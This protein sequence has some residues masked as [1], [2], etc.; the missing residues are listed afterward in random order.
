MRAVAVRGERGSRRRRAWSPGAARSRGSRGSAPRI[1]S[2]AVASTANRSPAS[3]PTSTWQPGLVEGDR[4]RARQRPARDDAR[5][6]PGRRRRA[7]EPV[8]TQ[9]RSP[10]RSPEPDGSSRRGSTAA[11]RTGTPRSLAAATSWP[12]KATIPR[13][14]RV[15][16]EVR[17]GPLVDVV[18]DAV[19]PGLEELRGGAGVV[20]LVEVHPGRV[21]EPVRAQDQRADHEHDQEPQVQPVQ[22]PSRLAG[23]ARAIGRGGSASRPIAGAQPRRSAPSPSR[24]AGRTRRARGGRGNGC[25]G[26]GWPPRPGRRPGHRHGRPRPRHPRPP[27][28]PRRHAGSVASGR[29]RLRLRP[30]T[31]PRSGRAPAGAASARRAPRAQLQDAPGERRRVEQGDHRHA[32]RRPDRA[33]DPQPVRDLGLSG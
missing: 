24:T 1:A 10:A 22:A 9:T 11:S 29:A 12:A 30:G 19:A 26:H 7:R 31:P 27:R 13:G 20:D 17:V 18:G 33:T 32:E 25:R 16:G 14:H 15:L 5:G 4:A 2:S 21:V 28:H 6:S 3:V 8:A 23:E